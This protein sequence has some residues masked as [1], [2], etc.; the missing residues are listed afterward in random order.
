MSLCFRIILPSPHG[1][2]NLYPPHVK[3]MAALWVET[4]DRHQWQSS[5]LA[6]LRSTD[7]THKI[8][9]SIFMMPQTKILNCGA[10][11]RQ[12]NGFR[13]I[14]FRSSW[15]TLLNLQHRDPWQRVKV[16]IDLGYRAITVFYIKRGDF[17]FYT[18][19]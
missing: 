6:I 19:F 14:T 5:S 17:K 18:Q 3:Y 12:H 15:T 10:V 1:E 11:V 13:V 16:V 9:T 7:G 8:I 2:D 4:G